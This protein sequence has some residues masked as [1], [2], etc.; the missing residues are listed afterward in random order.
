METKNFENSVKFT[1]ALFGGQ[2]Y[3][4]PIVT[5]DVIGRTG[6]AYPLPFLFDTGATFTMLKADLY[7]IFGL[8]SWDDGGIKVEV[9]MSSKIFNYQ[10]DATLEIFG[11]QITCPI[12]LTQGLQAHPLY[13][14]LLGRDTIFKEFGFGFWESVHELYVTKNP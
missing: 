2:I 7:P 10:Y 8:S 11:K 3:W 13:S 9:A 14:G 4:L 5:V 12:H 6:K 1:R